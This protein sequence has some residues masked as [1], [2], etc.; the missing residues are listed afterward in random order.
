MGKFEDWLEKPFTIKRWDRMKSKYAEVPLTNG[1]VY[2]ETS[3]LL[4]LGFGVMFVFLALMISDTPRLAQSNVCGALT[5]INMQYVSHDGWNCTY[6][7]QE[8]QTIETY[9]A[10]NDY[11]RNAYV[12]GKVEK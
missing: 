1:S 10:V 4:F 5:P 7:N 6:L 9:Q 2:Y 12:L 11:S 8:N 3:W